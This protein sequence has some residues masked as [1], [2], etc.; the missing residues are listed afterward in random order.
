M[1][2]VSKTELFIQLEESLNKY[3]P[4]LSQ[5]SNLVLQKQVTR[6]PIYVFYQEPDIDIGLRLVDRTVNMGLWNIR[7]SSLEEFK[8]KG[9]ISG[10]KEQNFRESFKDPDDFY[11]LFVLSELGAQF[12]YL[13]R[14]QE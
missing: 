12:I 8:E 4:I 2:E 5:A 3:Q 14:K 11:C 1:E 10:R 13:P 9:L 6:Y 7:V